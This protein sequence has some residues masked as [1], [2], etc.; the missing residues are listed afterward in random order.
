M[1]ASWPKWLPSAKFV[2]KVQLPNLYLRNLHSVTV[3]CILHSTYH[4][5]WEKGVEED[6]RVSASNPFN[7]TYRM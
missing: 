7:S 4:R 6:S 1:F 3:N 5:T 2:T